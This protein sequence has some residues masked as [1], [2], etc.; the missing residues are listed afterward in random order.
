MASNQIAIRD[1]ALKCGAAFSMLY[2]PLAKD[3]FDELY[4]QFFKNHNIRIWETAITCIFELLDR[5][6]V[7]SFIVLEEQNKS[8]KTGRQLYNTLEFVDADEDTHQS[9]TL[10]QGVGVIYM[11]SHFLD[12]CDD[13]C[14]IRAIINGFCR[15][16][17]HGHI[18]NHDVVEKLLLRY[19]NP[20]TGKIVI[21]FLLYF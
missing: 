15:L 17:L 2:E 19:F 18:I 20:V 12:T 11:M 13:M 9:T 6:G 8:K 16:V 1:W 5:Y 7:D 21:F 10:G 4:A 14:I 3:V